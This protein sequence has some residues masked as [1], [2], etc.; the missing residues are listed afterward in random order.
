MEDCG[1]LTDTAEY[2]P[3]K[4]KLIL[5]VSF[6]VSSGTKYNAWQAIGTPSI[7]VE[8]NKSEHCQAKIVTAEQE[9]KIQV[10]GESLGQA[11][12]RT[13]Y[14]GVLLTLNSLSPCQVLP[15]Q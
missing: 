1:G 3:L 2:Q 8:L 13:G 11:L 9:S 12:S 15:D 6:F 10:P 14:A 4:D 7:C 5:K